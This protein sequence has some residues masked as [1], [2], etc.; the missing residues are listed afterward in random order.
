[1]KENKEEITQQK[2]YAC[3]L[4]TIY[5]I[6]SDMKYKLLSAVGSVQGIYHI[7]EGQLTTII[8]RKGCERFCQHKNRY[9][10]QKVWN[11]M[12]KL[13]IRYTYCED[14]D[15]PKKLVNIPDPPFGI[16][17]KGKL[18]SKG[19][20]A[21][22][23]IG[24]RKCSEYGRYMAE[25]FATVFAMHGINVISGM[26]QGIDGISQ[27][28]ALAAGGNSY[29]VLGCGVDVV[30]PKVNEKLYYQLLEQGG[31]LSE[32]PPQMEP[33][34]M[35]FPPRNRIISALS[36]VVLVVEAREKSGS[37]IT[38]D[39]ALEQGKEVYIVPGR[40]TDSLSMGC[41]R[42]LRQGAAIATTPED[43]IEDMY[44][45]TRLQKANNPLEKE[46]NDKNDIIRKL[47]STTKELYA[48][49]DVLPITQDVI[50]SRLRDKKKALSI[51]Q[52][53]QGL[54]ELELKGLVV[55]ENRQYRKI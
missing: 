35:L 29:A 45:E 43:I 30:Y 19:V 18:P 46:E 16:F 2:Q 33:R 26:A 41:N 17:Y 5:W 37:L 3:W 27:K 20:P 15:F 9:T 1:M 12:K 49:L 48:I 32:Y 44:W 55:S 31:V 25:N 24:A 7:E 47:S 11:Y 53:C 22:A 23:M 54:V 6:T 39:M 21:I 50:V 34:P 51:P 36:D 14:S 13:G 40:C 38:V 8:G 52:I 10:P 42:L 4:D 28:S